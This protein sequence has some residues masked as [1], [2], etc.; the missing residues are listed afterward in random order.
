MIEVCTSKVGAYLWISESTSVGIN[1]DGE[2]P[3]VYHDLGARFYTILLIF[4]LEEGGGR[5]HQEIS[6][7]EAF[8]RVLISKRMVSV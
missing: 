5:E 7:S 6:L 2:I 4:L 1:S 8:S 3:M